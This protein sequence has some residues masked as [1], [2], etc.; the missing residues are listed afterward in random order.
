MILETAGL[1]FLG[2]GTQ[3]PNADLGSMLGQG[4]AQMFVAPHVALVPGIMIFLIVISF[5][6]L[7]DGVRDILDPRL[8]SGALH[9][10]QPMTQT[11][12]VNIPAKTEGKQAILEVKD[13]SVAFRQ[14][15]QLQ[16]YR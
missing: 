15:G 12:R 8:K 14:G 5:N 9:R 16:Y 6:L 10:S 3:P 13:L 1:S 7:G 2:L 4:R 11:D